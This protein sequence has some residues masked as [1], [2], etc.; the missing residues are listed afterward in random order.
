MVCV[1]IY[2]YI[3]IYI[4]CVNMC[5]DIYTYITIYMSFRAGHGARDPFPSRAG[6]ACAKTS[7][8]NIPE[9]SFR[10]AFPPSKLHDSFCS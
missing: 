2:I 3:Y 6:T 1:C 5:M 9:P 10:R 8:S 7:R 4:T